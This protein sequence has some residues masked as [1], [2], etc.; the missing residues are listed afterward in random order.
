MIC[1]CYNIFY[2]NGSYH[3]TVSPRYVHS[4]HMQSLRTRICVVQCGVE[5]RTR[6]N[7]T[8]LQASVKSVTSIPQYCLRI[9]TRN[10]TWRCITTDHMLSMSAVLSCNFRNADPY[11]MYLALFFLASS[12]IHLRPT[13]TYFTHC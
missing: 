11:C 13:V 9:N 8:Q 2:P 1:A 5:I 4:R 6:W 10:D 12:V 3:W 7:N